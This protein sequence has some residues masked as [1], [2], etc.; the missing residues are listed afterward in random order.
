MANEKHLKNENN[1]PMLFVSDGNPSYQAAVTYL[2]SQNI[3]VDL[4]Q[5]IGL[6]NKDE[7]SAMYRY[8]KNLVE[9]VNRTY[10]NY[11][12]NCF[13]KIENAS[14]NLALAVT[15]YNFIRP[16]SSLEYQTPVMKD[17]LNEIPLIQNIWAKILSSQT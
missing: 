5:V 11:A 7:V 1:D 12:V 3:D 17:E 10:K 2:K 9:R 13:K 16:H 14:A 8:M 6:E 15:N 4:K